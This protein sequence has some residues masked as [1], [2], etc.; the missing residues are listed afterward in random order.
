MHTWRFTQLVQK[1][2]KNQWM[3]HGWHCMQHEDIM[4]T[5]EI[6]MAKIHREGKINT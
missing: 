3:L 6:G 5:A 4:M 1:K 2:M